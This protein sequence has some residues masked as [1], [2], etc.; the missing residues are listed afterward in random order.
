[1]YEI[2]SELSTIKSCIVC[3]C[4]ASTFPTNDQGQEIDCSSLV[5]GY[6]GY[7]KYGNMKMK[8]SDEVEFS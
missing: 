5:F 4:V 1:M 7:T 3:R 6:G 2:M 8:Q